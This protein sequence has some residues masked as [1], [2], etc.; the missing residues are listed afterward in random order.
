MFTTRRHYERSKK[1]LKLAGAKKLG[2]RSWQGD[3]NGVFWLKSELF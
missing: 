2:V 1:V 3:E